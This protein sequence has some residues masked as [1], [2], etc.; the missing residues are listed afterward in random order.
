MTLLSFF[1]ICLLIY[2]FIVFV[3]YLFQARLLFSP[4]YYRNEEKISA[5]EKSL[6][7][8]SLPAGD[9]ALLEGIFYLPEGASKKVILYFGGVQQDSVA[10]VEKFASH[11]P[12][13]P[14]ISYNYRGY[15]RSEGK[16][17]QSRLFEDAMHIYDDLIVRYDYKPE[18]IIL[19]GYSLGTGVASFLAS[20]RKV[21]EILLM[22]P[23]DSVYEVMKK[24][25]PFSGIHWVLKQR[26]PSVDFVPH[27]D[28]P[29]HVY[30]ASDDK[31][32]N[33]KH[34]KMLKNHIKNLAGFY[35]Y[36]NVGHNDILFNTDVVKH[37]KEILE[38]K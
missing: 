38:K 33:I 22:A 3:F 27:I 23:Y 28:V 1:G 37:I 20:Q 16:P 9:E 26:F 11:Y 15:G 31:V 14:F 8:L 36:G 12:R 32:V 21:R 25:Y 5:I 18:D 29:I 24:R 10:L 13:M 2:A 19:M 17:S 6:S 35:E 30:A 4:V 34:A 7:F